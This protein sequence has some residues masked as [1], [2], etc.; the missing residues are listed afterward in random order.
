[1][2][3]PTCYY[4]DSDHNRCLCY[5]NHDLDDLLAENAKL[6]EQIQDAEHEESVAWDRVH[7][8]E[9][10]MRRAKEHNAKLRKLCEDMVDY[11]EGAGNGMAKFFADR[12][13][14]LG[15]KEDQG[16]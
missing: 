6:R 15:I 7:T 11:G 3:D 1:M 2:N 12:M 8:A 9:H 10:Q 13:R 16:D 14:E 4:Y 5:D